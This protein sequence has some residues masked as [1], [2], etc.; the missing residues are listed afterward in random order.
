MFRKGENIM[1]LY[2]YTLVKIDDITCVHKTNEDKNKEKED[3]FK[4]ENC[5][6]SI[7]K[8][9]IEVSEYEFKNFIKKYPRKL[10]RDIYRVF[11]PPLISYND[12]EFG[13]FPYSIAA[14]TSAYSNNPKDYYYCSPKERKYY[15]CKNYKEVFESINIKKRGY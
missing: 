11:E 8:E 15:I 7:N 5:Y 10:E 2:G 12:F 3:Y 13:C 6:I 9:M 4:D 14:Q 1:D